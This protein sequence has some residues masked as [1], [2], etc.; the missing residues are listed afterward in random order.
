MVKQ[1]NG[2]TGR[3]ALLLFAMAGGVLMLLASGTGQAAAGGGCV[4][5]EVD[6]PIRLPDGTLHPPGK[7]TLCD[8]MQ[9]SPVS[10]LHKTYVNGQPVGMLIGRKRT[11]EGGKRMSPVVF[12]NVDDQGTLEL[13]GYVLPAGGGSVTYMIGGA[14]I[15]RRNFESASQARGS[16][17][18]TAMVAGIPR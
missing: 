17:Q 10:S 6:T 14:R 11:S 4:S 12:F 1:S 18:L 8:S 16:R 3:R 2:L 15:S 7:L 13:F 5:V 9:L